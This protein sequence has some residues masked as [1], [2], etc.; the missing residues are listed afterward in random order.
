MSLQNINLNTIESNL[1]TSYNDLYIKQALANLG[2]RIGTKGDGIKS[3]YFT[4]YEALEYKN[5]LSNIDFIC[6]QYDSS[7]NNIKCILNSDIPLDTNENV[8]C[9]IS[10]SNILYSDSDPINIYIVEDIGNISK[11]INCKIVKYFNKYYFIGLGYSDSNDIEEIV[12][13]EINVNSNVLLDS[14]VFVRDKE[15][16]SLYNIVYYNEKNPIAK[17][18]SISLSYDELYKLLLVFNDINEVKNYINNNLMISDSDIELDYYVQEFIYMENIVCNYIRDIYNDKMYIKDETIFVKLQQQIIGKLVKTLYDESELNTTIFNVYFKPTYKFVYLE[19]D[20][21]GVY[22]ISNDFVVSYQNLSNNILP[23]F[24]GL[25]NDFIVCDG[26]QEKFALYNFEIDYIKDDKY[27]DKYVNNINIFKRFTLPYISFD[28]E[29]AKDIWYINDLKTNIPAIGKDAGN[30]NI[31][32]AT[33]I[34]HINDE[35]KYSIDINIQHSYK[36]NYINIDELKYYF[37]NGDIYNFKYNLDNKNIEQINNSPET[38]YNF[39][40]TLPNLNLLLQR[41]GYERIIN[42]CL[43]FTIIDLKISDNAVNGNTLQNRINGNSNSTS[44]ITVFWHVI[45]KDN[46]YLWEPIYNLAYASNELDVNNNLCPV[47]DLGSMLSVRDI[48]NY[49]VNTQYSPD[50]YEHSWVVFDPINKIIKQSD[51]SLT[52]YNTDDDKTVYPVFKVDNRSYYKINDIQNQYTNDLQFVPKFLFKENII[53]DGIG[54]TFINDVDNLQ[55]KHFNISDESKIEASVKINNDYVPNSTDN[56]TYPIFDFKEVLTNNQTALNR[57]NIISVDD[58]NTIY[59]AYIGVNGKNESDKDVLVIGTDNSNYNMYQ[60]KTLTNDFN[61]FKKFKK[62][63][64]DIPVTYEGTVTT[65]NIYINYFPDTTRYKYALIPIYLN[66]YISSTGEIT[67]KKYFKEKLRT[68][69]SK[70]IDQNNNYIVKDLTFNIGSYLIDIFEGKLNISS[71][72]DEEIT[73]TNYSNTTNLIGFTD[74]KNKFRLFY[75]I[76]DLND[77]E[78]IVINVKE[79]N[80]NV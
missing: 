61:N 47:L 58:N 1:E 54:I 46:K 5:D 21:T 59:N 43:L 57:I 28:N 69:S 33:Y 2:Q 7:L 23:K 8:I 50:V 9:N 22:Y 44:F 41:P 15:N 76:F 14:I 66:N 17:K 62:L 34:K 70:W 30:P 51:E 26:L 16:Q 11:Y 13:S 64:F 29:L 24:N 27:V 65:E 3:N 18:T 52:T 37:D 35:N 53:S 71:Y 12:I 79:I 77:D 75:I 72:V 38:L 19:N 49:Y 68:Y 45:Y 39:N 36:D 74:D 10:L 32:F 80:L 40:I 48:I 20:N 4:I 73:L 42:N 63:V 25:D 78:Y 56:T 31:M 55:N 6:F 60:N 67:N